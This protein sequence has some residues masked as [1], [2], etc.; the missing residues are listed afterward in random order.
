MASKV[1]DGKGPWKNEKNPSQTV[2]SKYTKQR[3]DDEDTQYDWAQRSMASRTAV[4][5]TKKESAAG[6]ELTKIEGKLSDPQFN[7]VIKERSKRK[8]F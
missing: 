4:P 2:K 7:D 1:K 5:Q 6:R 8:K 3:Q